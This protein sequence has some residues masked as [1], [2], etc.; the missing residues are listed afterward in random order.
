MKNQVSCEEL[1]AALR[2]EVEEHNGIGLRGEQ[3]LYPSSK[4]K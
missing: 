2:N 4:G 1:E 3:A